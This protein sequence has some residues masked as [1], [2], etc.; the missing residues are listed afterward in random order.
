MRRLFRKRNVLFSEKE[1]F[2]VV[3]FDYRPGKGNGA[4]LA[5][6]AL[7]AAGMTVA[8]WLAVLCG[9]RAPIDGEC[10]IGHEV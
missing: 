10:S 1:M 9:I 8:S 3:L 6:I 5:S 2:G 4:M 7:A